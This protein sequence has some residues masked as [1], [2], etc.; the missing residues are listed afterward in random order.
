MQ[1]ALI[2]ISGVYLER[3]IRD[4][5]TPG[6]DVGFFVSGIKTELCSKGS[7]APLSG[8]PLDAKSS[9]S[10]RTDGLD[11]KSETPMAYHPNLH[12][13]F[14]YIFKIKSPFFSRCDQTDRCTH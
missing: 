1:L 4:S 5:Q 9:E 10:A 6:D 8:G 12:E 2:D 13:S 14:A 7:I 3:M 11:F